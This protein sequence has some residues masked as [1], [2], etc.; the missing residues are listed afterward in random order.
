[1]VS[2]CANPACKMEFKYFREGKLFEFE[3]RGNKPCDPAANKEAKPP[4]TRVLYWLCDRCSQSL[5]LA[6]RPESGV[7]VVPVD[8]RDRLT[9]PAA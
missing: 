3:M 2:K 5:T 8:T 1:M 9:R 4:Q 6:C 7:V